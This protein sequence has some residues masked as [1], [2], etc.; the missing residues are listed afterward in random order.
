MDLIDDQSSDD[1][2]P[3]NTTSSQRCFQES[4]RKIFTFLE[5]NNGIKAMWC[6]LCTKSNK[7]TKW[8]FN[9]ER[10][11]KKLKTRTRG[12]SRFKIDSIR[13]H[14]LSTHHREAISDHI[15]S[16]SLT[17]QLANMFDKATSEIK[18][19]IS[20]VIFMSKETIANVK[21]QSLCAFIKSFGIKLTDGDL[22][23]SSY[24]YLEILKTLSEVILKEQIERLKETTHY[25][26]IIDE[27]TDI[28][29]QKELIVYVKY[30]N[31]KT[32]K[33]KTEFLKLMKLTDFTAPS[34]V[35][36]LRSTFIFNLCLF[37]KVF[38]KEIISCFKI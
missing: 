17:N 2:P 36:E 33:I 16:V 13:D 34:I 31:M 27:S 14:A 28:T 5:Y 10:I 8:N 25:S 12:I 4:W 35:H 11:N 7:T 3:Q 18:R 20:I 9:K 26:I 38:L 30:L 21:Y 6:K 15:Q 1:D 29:H 32:C 24:A 19:L 37:L 22:Y 23:I